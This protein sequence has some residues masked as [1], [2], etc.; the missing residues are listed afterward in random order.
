[1]RFNEMF[2]R[3]NVARQPNFSPHLMK[4]IKM[5]KK[6]FLRIGLLGLVLSVFTTTKA[7]ASYTQCILF[8]ERH[9]SQLAEA[10]GSEYLYLACWDSLRPYCGN[11]FL[12]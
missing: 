3:A 9:C 2:P 1:M 8:V 10:G 11:P 7:S 5:K 6:M 12:N 4:E